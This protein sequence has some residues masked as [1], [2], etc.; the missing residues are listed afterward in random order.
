MIN[1][2]IHWTKENTVNVVTWVLVSSI[3]ILF[4]FLI[5][6]I[7]LIFD[8][9]SN[10]RYILMPFIVGGCIAYILNFFVNFMEDTL[11]KV[12]YFGK[13]NKKSLR[14]ISMII[15]YII[16][17]IF[18]TL[19]LRYIIPQFYL[20]VKGFIEQTPE[21]VE[22]SINRIRGFL[23]NVEINDEFKS[24][25]TGKLTEFANF[26]TKFLT[27]L[28]PYVATFATR[29]I[30]LFLNI[31][32]AII[33]SAYILY[34][35]E[36]F[37]KNSKKMVFALCSDRVST[38]IFKILRKFDETLKSY[39]IA[40]GI[41]AI[42]VGIIFYV[43]LLF[44][45]VEYALLFAFILGFTNLIPWF[46][47]YLGAIPVTIVLMMSSFKMAMWFVLIVFVV[48]M[49]DG[50]FISPKLSSKSLGIS[51]FWV[52]FALVLGGSLFGV[53]GFF[54]AVPVFVVIYSLI[55]E[56]VEDKLK[57]KGIDVIDV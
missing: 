9:I 26:S 13:M 4:Y 2:K 27:D 21:F 55:K 38:N 39:L 12:D 18:M 5:L 45:K 29:T 34:D 35:K 49:I 42:I 28:I 11:S 56:F 30:S 50:N 36:N 40:K 10:I 33:I 1:L 54:L 14:G 43:V 57:K 53:L 8:H 37:S 7:S 32:L 24:I 52:I 15:V 22:N 19:L 16:T 3:S 46:G 41:G 47:S 48:G 25:L 6:N 31:I 51:S 44:M 20:N 17:I 23:E